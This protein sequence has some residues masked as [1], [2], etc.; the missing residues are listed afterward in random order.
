MKFKPERVYKV[1]VNDLI[2]NLFGPNSNLR[3]NNF[4]ALFACQNHLMKLPPKKIPNLKVKPLLMSMEFIFPL[5]WMLGVAFS[6]D[7]MTRHFKG[8]HTDK[9]RITYK[10]KGDGLQTYAICQKGYTYQI[11]MCNDPSP[12]FF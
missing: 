12:I 1:H 6:I 5:I 9:R 8:H 4:K 3:Q 10:E 11:I 7:E 2:Y